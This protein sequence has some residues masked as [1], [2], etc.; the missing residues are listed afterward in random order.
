MNDLGKVVYFA[1]VCVGAWQIG[2]VIG[3]ALACR[4]AYYKNGGR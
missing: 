2:S 1:V 3:E 4:R